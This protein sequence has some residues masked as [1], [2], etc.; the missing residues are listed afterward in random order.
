MFISPFTEA[1]SCVCSLFPCWPQVFYLGH[2]MQLS[3]SVYM[4]KTFYLTS[5]ID[6]DPETKQLCAAML[7]VS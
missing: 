3:L 4:V 1:L 2:C 5:K 7:H 6:V